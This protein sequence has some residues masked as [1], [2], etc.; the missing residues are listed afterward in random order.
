MYLE[1]S[2]RSWLN[3]VLFLPFNAGAALGACAAARTAGLDPRFG[4]GWRLVGVAWAVSGVGSLLW[5][6]AWLGRGPPGWAASV[7]YN[8]YYPLLFAG[9]WLLIS[10]PAGR[11]AR[12]RL[13]FEAL[14]VA[15]ATVT[16]AWYFDLSP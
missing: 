16:F 1:P 15:V 7:V 3:D 12:T 6:V 5:T 14:I 4:R 10:L 13:A 8:L 11:R 9:L 2:R